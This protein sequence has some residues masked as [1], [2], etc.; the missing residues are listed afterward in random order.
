METDADT[1]SQ[2]LIEVRKSYER[3]G[4][5]LKNTKGI[6]TPQ[7]NQQSELTWT[8]GG[9]QRLNHQPKSLYGLDLVPRHL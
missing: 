5:R 9:S 7:G 1:H 8:L 6:G 4:K 2:M 3:V